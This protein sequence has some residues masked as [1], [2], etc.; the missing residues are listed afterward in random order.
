MFLEYKET[1]KEYLGTLATNIANGLS[2]Y[3]ALSKLRADKDLGYIYLEMAVLGELEK[4]I[5]K[6]NN[7]ISQFLRYKHET[8]SKIQD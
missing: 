5:E 1:G 3:A 6:T 2:P 8:K 7:G 4:N